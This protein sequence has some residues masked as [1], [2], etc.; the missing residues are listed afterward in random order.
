M[1]WMDMALGL[2]TV[3]ALVEQ[4]TGNVE[5]AHEQMAAPDLYTAGRRFHMP[6]M[7]TCIASD[8]Q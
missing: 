3:K 6:L 2:T 1:S 8:P 4:A 5:A 7:R